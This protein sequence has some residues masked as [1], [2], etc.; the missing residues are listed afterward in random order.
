MSYRRVIITEFGGPEVLKVVEE[1]VLPKPEPGEV[2][3]KVLATSASFTDTMIR[4]GVYRDVKE[5]PP[6]SPGYDMVGVVDELGAGV[7]CRM[8]R[9]IKCCTDR[10]KYSEASASWSTAQAAPSARRCSNWA[11]CSTWRCMGRRPGP[12]TS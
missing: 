7:T 11:N 1:A 6:F 2:R 3:V 12:S 4:K 10:P 9:R 5:K 8:S